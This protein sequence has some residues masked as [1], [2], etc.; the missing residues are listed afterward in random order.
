MTK[1]EIPE[2]T[3]S[4]DTEQMIIREIRLANAGDNRFDIS[5]P[6]RAGSFRPYRV[7]LAYRVNRGS[8]TPFWY[9]FQIK[10]SA[11]RVLKSGAV[12]TAYASQIEESFYLDRAPEWAR[13]M[14]VRLRPT[15]ETER[16]GFGEQQDV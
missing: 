5:S 2:F 10:I 11:N 12:S 13:E 1:T 9:V 16:R 15:V 3:S 14:G 8:G 4:V 7:K 6:Y